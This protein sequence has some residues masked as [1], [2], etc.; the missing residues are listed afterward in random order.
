MRFFCRVA[1]DTVDIELMEASL[2]T[3]HKRGNGIV[4]LKDMN[5]SEVGRD[6]DEAKAGRKNVGIGLCRGGDWASAVVLVIVGCPSGSDA[7]EGA[8]PIVF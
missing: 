3:W 2:R 6:E 4:L 8:V 1:R 5:G 7:V